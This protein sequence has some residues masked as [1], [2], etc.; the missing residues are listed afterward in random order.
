MTTLNLVEVPV[1][2]PAIFTSNPVAAY[3]LNDDGLTIDQI[4]ESARTIADLC[5][6]TM[7]T[8]GWKVS[9]FRG[10]KIVY[11]TT[12][13]DTFDGTIS[14]DIS[15]LWVLFY[16]IDDAATFKRDFSC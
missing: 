13:P 7:K 8:D 3:K 6:Q 9:L 15:A 5:A 4:D 14:G 2:D 16:D 10:Q 11:D 12:N 1:D